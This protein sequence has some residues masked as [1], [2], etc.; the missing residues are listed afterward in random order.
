MSLL[1]HATTIPATAAEARER[2]KKALQRAEE[3]RACCF[4]ETHPGREAWHRMEEARKE[5]RA[6]F[7]ELRRI[8]AQEPPPKVVRSGTVGRYRTPR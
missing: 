6:A 4:G 2:L 8:Q 3:L 1:P 5:V 7:A